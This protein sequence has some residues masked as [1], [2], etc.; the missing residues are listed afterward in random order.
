M[1]NTALF[2]APAAAGNNA[3]EAEYAPTPIVAT[4]ISGSNNSLDL[5]HAYMQ[6]MWNMYP[7]LSYASMFIYT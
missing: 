7:L 2:A 1:F 5:H 4:S 6:H 3:T